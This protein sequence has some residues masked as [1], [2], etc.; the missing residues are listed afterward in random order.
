MIDDSLK[1]FL[2]KDYKHCR[3]YY[4]NQIFMCMTCTYHTYS[5]AIIKKICASIVRYPRDLKNTIFFICIREL[6]RRN[7]KDAEW[8][9][10]NFKNRCKKISSIGST[11]VPAR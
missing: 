6:S 3:F 5:D 8:P 1:N 11:T 4:H 9:Q 10:R 7:S 2:I